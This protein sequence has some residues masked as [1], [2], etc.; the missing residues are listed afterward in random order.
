MANVQGILSLSLE[1]P[2]LSF[3]PR[4]G[5]SKDASACDCTSADLSRILLE[6]GFDTNQLQSWPPKELVIRWEGNFP[7]GT[8]SKF[9]LLSS[10]TISE[11][12]NAELASTASLL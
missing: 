11:T 3:Q 12:E 5:S 4:E 6:L 7:G 8:L 9:G 1:P 2:Y 10:L